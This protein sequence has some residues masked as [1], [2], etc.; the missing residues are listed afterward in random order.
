MKY[1]EN[2]AEFKI[3][4][5]KFLSKTGKITDTWKK[6]IIALTK[7]HK[8]K[9]IKKKYS[10]PIKKEKLRQKKKKE[11]KKYIENMFQLAKVADFDTYRQK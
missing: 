7:F 10:E 2:F 9:V 6:N 1:P 5:H 3:Q 8:E 11:K 4:M